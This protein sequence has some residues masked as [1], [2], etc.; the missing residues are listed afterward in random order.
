[1]RSVQILKL[2]RSEHCLTCRGCFQSRSRC[3]ISVVT[4]CHELTSKLTMPHFWLLSMISSKYSNLIGQLEVHYFTFGPPERSHKYRSNVALSRAR[5]MYNATS[6]CSSL[7]PRPNVMVIV[8][9]FRDLDRPM[10]ST[11]L[12]ALVAPSLHS[13][14]LDSVSNYFI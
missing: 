5:K 4:E 7:I 2:Y 1:M 14:T 8:A 11:L 6:T 13:G 9:T 12:S 10:V 3:I